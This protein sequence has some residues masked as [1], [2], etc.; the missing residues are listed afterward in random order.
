MLLHSSN[1]SRSG[2]G[3]QCA[4][5]GVALLAGSPVSLVSSLCSVRAPV[6]AKVKAGDAWA[7]PADL[8]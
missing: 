5:E 8:P 6:V 2:S 4:A 3:E 7:A 1:A